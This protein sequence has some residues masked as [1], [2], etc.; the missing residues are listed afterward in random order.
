[1]SIP[2][3]I[4]SDIPMSSLRPLRTRVRLPAL[5]HPAR[6]LALGDALPRHDGCGASDAAAATERSQRT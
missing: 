2:P 5:R 6:E 3:N 1:M 4:R